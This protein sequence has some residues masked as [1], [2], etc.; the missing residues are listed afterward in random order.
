[1][2]RKVL[3][4]IFSLILAFASV[5]KSESSLAQFPGGRNNRIL[6]EDALYIS[7]GI[8]DVVGCEAFRAALR[9]YNLIKNKDRELLT[10]I[11][12]TKPSTDERMVIIDMKQ[13]KVLL[14]SLVAHGRNSGEMYATRFSNREGSYMSSLGFYLTGDTYKGSNGYS[15]KLYGLEKGVN[16]NALERAIVLHG[17]DY[18]DPCIVAKGQRLGRSLGCPAVPRQVAHKVIDTIKEGSV[19]FIYAEDPWYKTHSAYL[20]S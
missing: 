16:D 6:L 17:A 3:F 9:G 18:C 11:D 12:F 8:D 7:L 10:L 20:A 13:G 4:A 1:M 14:K 15:L 2:L 5:S 19:L